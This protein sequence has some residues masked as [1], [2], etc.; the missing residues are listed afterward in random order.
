[1][2][3]AEIDSFLTKFKYLCSEG[4]NASL[5][6]TSSNGKAIVTLHAEIGAIGAPKSPKTPVK[7]RSPAYNRR[8][9]R[10]Q[11][12]R[13]TSDENHLVEAGEASTEF[14]TVT[15]NEAL[16]PVM[17]YDVAEYFNC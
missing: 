15:V 3:D 16:K 9:A 14:G 5:N 1:M 12:M 13:Q 11:A 17:V 2:A 8:I 10:R 6:I 4:I 7:H